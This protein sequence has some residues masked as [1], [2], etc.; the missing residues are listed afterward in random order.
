MFKK[1][2]NSI[3]KFLEKIADENKKTFGGEKLDCCGLNTEK[4]KS[5]GK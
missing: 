2:K 4:K 1:L 5:K 3:N